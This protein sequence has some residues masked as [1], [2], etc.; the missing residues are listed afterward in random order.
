MLHGCCL[1]F[2]KEYMNR[3]E[4]LNPKTFLY[5]EEELLF[6]RLKHYNLLSLYDDEITIIHT[7]NAST[8]FLYPDKRKKE[9]FFL[10][11]YIKS[12]KILLKELKKENESYYEK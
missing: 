6:L 7:E 3:F 1:I 4:G 12:N 11:N 8:N 2:S 9:I 10:K 5:C